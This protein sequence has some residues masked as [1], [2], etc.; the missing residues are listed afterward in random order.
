MQAR[1]SIALGLTAVLV[2]GSLMLA[3]SS[4]PAV[5]FAAHASFIGVAPHAAASQDSVK[6]MTY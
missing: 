3:Q 4:A 1:Q 5:D 2:T 6:D